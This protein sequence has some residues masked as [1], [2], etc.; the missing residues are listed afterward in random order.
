[1]PRIAR[2]APGGS[3]FH[4]LNRANGK[5]KL[6]RTD[7]DYLAFE[8]LLAEAHERFPMRI[9]D[10]CV[11]PNHWHMVLWPRRDG[12]LSAFIGWLSLTHAQRWKTA[13]NAI[14]HGHL[15]QGRF[16]S[17]MIGPD[18]HLLTVLRYIERNPLRAKMVKRA[19][20]W[21][22]GSLW[23]R[24]KGGAQ[25]RALLSEWPVDMRSDWMQWVNQP[26]TPAEM[27]AIR[28]SIKRDRPFG[29]ESWVRGTVKR[30]NLEHTLRPPGRQVG[31][32]KT[33]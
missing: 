19:E 2:V 14:G 23:V 10:W 15:Y 7:G 11:M 8:K 22:W 5:L 28:V 17:F 18:E 3:I 13:H 1:M 29:S 12:E 33:K 25:L 20:D 21:R 4:V 6:F 27:E 9:L 24:H 31:W 32:R 26:Q 30:L 16:K